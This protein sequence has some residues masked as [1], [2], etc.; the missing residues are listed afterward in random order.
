MSVFHDKKF[1]ELD[2]VS[3]AIEPIE[4]DL[5]KVIS[6]IPDRVDIDY[7]R[8]LQLVGDNWDLSLSMTR[9]VRQLISTVECEISMTYDTLASIEKCFKLEIQGEPILDFTNKTITGGSLSLVK[10]NALLDEDQ[11]KKILGRAGIEK[12]AFSSLYSSDKECLTRCNDV[13]QILGSCDSGLRSSS[14]RRKRVAIKDR[15]INLFKTNEWNIKDTTLADKVGFWIIEYV[16]DG[17]LAAYSNFCRLKVMTHRGQPIYS[18][19]EVV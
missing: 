17:N 18:M 10:V 16:K 3:Q 9:I 13:M 4:S 6:L 14:L 15:L 11:L 5:N 8:Y 2:W 7:S 1:E 12:F 19:E